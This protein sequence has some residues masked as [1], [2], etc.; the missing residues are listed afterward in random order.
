MPQTS[1]AK[2]HLRV[3]ARKR[4]IN[5]RWRRQVREAVHAFRAA[6]TAG[7]S[8]K[9]KEA[10]LKTESVIDRAARHHVLHRN[11]AARK[12]SRFARALAT[13]AKNQ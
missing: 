9:A 5:D 10:F 7:D 1:S 13:L 2:K 6:L 4:V 11:A 3:S 8:A 12:K